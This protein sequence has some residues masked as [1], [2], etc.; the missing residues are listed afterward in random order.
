MVAMIQGPPRGIKRYFLV[1]RDDQQSDAWIDY[2]KPSV[3]V[4]VVNM[5]EEVPERILQDKCWTDGDALCY[6]GTPTDSRVRAAL[7]MIG[8][9]QELIR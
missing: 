2:I 1:A 4:I 3:P 6:A 7:K 5:A 9:P 8:C